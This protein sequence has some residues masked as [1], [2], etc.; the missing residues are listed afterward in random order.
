MRNAKLG[1]WEFGARGGQPDCRRR[2]CGRMQPGRAE[3]RAKTLKAFVSSEIFLSLQASRHF[4]T[5]QLHTPVD[6][7]FSSAYVTWIAVSFN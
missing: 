3:S 5:S 7:I 6:S 2:A 1:A 4:G